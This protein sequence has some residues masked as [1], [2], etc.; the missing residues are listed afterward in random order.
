MIQRKTLA[1]FAL[2]LFSS[3]ALLGSGC[4]SDEPSGDGDSTVPYTFCAPAETCPPS[5]AGV[6]FDTPVSFKTDIYDAFLVNSCGGGSGCHASATLTGLALGTPAAPLNPSD[7]VADL[8]ARTSE[9]S[10]TK[11]VIPGDWENSFLMMKLDGCQNQSG[12]TCNSNAGSLVLSVCDQPCG[13]G[14]PQSEGDTANP[15]AYPL[16]KAQRDKVRAWIMQGALDN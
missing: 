11:N 16:T 2:P 12:L 8:K 1:F 15:N 14:M 13:D 4:S 3:A 10:G 7:V 5:V 9:I 6:D